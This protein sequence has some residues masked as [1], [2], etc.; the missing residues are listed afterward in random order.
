MIRTQQI[1]MYHASK[2][3]MKSAI[4][5]EKDPELKRSYA[6]TL[7][8][9]LG[10]PD[11]REFYAIWII[12]LHDETPVGYLCFKGLDVNGVIEIDY[13]ICPEY[14]GRGYAAEAVNA[15]V[16]WALQHPDVKSIEA[17]TDRHNIASQKVLAKCGFFPNG[18][19]G[20]EG[21]RYTF[22]KHRNLPVCGKKCCIIKLLGRGRGG[23]SYL[24]EYE[25]RQV[26]LKQ[27]HHEPCKSYNFGNKIGAE[28]YDYERLRNIGI[29]IP[30]MIDVDIAAERILKDYIEGPTIFDLIRKGVSIIPYLE[31]VQEMDRLA[32]ASGLH[33]DYYPTNF[34]VS[35][36]L[37]W[38]IDYECNNY[39]EQW[40]FEHWGKQNWVGET[41]KNN[42]QV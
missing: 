23:Y 19:L 3:L 29:R 32:K 10:Q 24:A 26:V 9:C 39:M 16:E 8:S 42:C 30:K 27:I 25:G 37:L 6:E 34:V 1:Q 13:G 41:E 4:A 38:Y 35:D 22:S 33:I 20:K 40:D 11:Q 12:E 17:E 14:Q 7:K 5:T 31:Q 18:I 21:P 28:C 15:A 2:E 36:D